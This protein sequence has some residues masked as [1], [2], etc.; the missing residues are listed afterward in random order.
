V[1]PCTLE[2]AWNREPFESLVRAVAFQQLHGRAANAILGRFVALFEP[3]FPTPA[4]I[5]DMDDQAAR[6]CGFSAAKIA[7]IRDIAAKA[8]AGLVPSRAEAETLPDEEIIARLVPIRGVGRWTVEMLLIS[9]LGRLDVWP[10]DDFGV[11]NGLKLLFGLDAMPRK[12]WMNEAARPWQPY[13]SMV[14]WYLWRG[15]DLATVEQ[16]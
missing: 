5:L 3:P 4:Q 6:A 10:T 11:K 7:A 8:E 12:G 9:T 15:A 14:S 2:P 1:G 16:A 13:R